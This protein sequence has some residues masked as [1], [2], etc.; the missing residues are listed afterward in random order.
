MNKIRLLFDYGCSP[1]WTY[2]E[3]NTMPLNG[4]PE[5]FSENGK[6]NGLFEQIEVEYYNLFINDE[7]TFKYKGFKC[8]SDKAAF[9]KKLNSAIELIKEVAGDRYLIINEW[10]TE[11]L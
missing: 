4:L 11:S 10:N 1:V 2:D 9:I 6:L 5:E 8:A 7:K 3:K